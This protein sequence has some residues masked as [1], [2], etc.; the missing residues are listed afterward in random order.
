MNVT[1]MAQW[2][3]VKTAIFFGSKPDVIFRKKPLFLRG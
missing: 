3:V 2:I 1:Q